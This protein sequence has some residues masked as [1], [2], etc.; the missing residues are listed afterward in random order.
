MVRNY[1]NIPK[2]YGRIFGRKVKKGPGLLGGALRIPTGFFSIIGE[3]GTLS[4]VSIKWS[5]LFIWGWARHNSRT[6]RQG[7]E[8]SMGNFPHW[9]VQL[10]SGTM[11][12]HS[13]R[14][15]SSCT[16]TYICI[17]IHII[18]MYAQ[19]EVNSRPNG[20]FY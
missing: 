20:V 9:K 7:E 16:Y 8:N 19:G 6:R 10:W 15:P 13:Q 17:H 12:A 14:D 5:N 18:Y 4:R 11:R 1:P 3:N 2:V